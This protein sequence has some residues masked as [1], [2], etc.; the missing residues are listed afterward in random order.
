MRELA[1]H[2]EEQRSYAELRE[3]FRAAHLIDLRSQMS[4]HPIGW[5]VIGEPG[6]SRAHYDSESWA[7][8]MLR[9][10]DTPVNQTFA[11]DRVPESVW[12]QMAEQAEKSLLH[13]SVTWS[14]DVGGVVDHDAAPCAPIESMTEEEIC[15]Y[16]EAA[17]AKH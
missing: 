8:E 16:V 2:P 14:D 5:G 1:P 3:E 4:K 9:H 15:N 7:R 13:E 10:L 17:I 12:K 6:R 11:L